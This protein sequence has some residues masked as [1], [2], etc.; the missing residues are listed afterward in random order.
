MGT[1]DCGMPLFQDCSS[2]RKGFLCVSCFVIVIIPGVF[3]DTT[4]SG[5]KIGPAMHC[6]LALYITRIHFV[7]DGT[8][9]C[10]VI[11]HISKKK[12]A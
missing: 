9:K 11:K 8:P 7:F 2:N 10:S 1:L 6:I 5:P 4:V 12:R 3:P